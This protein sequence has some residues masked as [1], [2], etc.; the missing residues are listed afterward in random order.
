[1]SQYCSSTRGMCVN[2]LFIAKFEHFDPRNEYPSWKNADEFSFKVYY[3]SEENHLSKKSECLTNSRGLM[4]TFISVSI[5]MKLH[6]TE[7]KKGFNLNSCK[8]EL[9]LTFHLISKCTFQDAQTD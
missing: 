5:N 3:I 9:Y 7:E 4:S 2:W 1:M 8:W 6:D